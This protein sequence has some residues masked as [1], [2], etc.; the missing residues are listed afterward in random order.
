MS[1]LLPKN[2]LQR[3]HGVAQK[4]P[5]LRLAW[6]FE[7]IERHR[8][9]SNLSDKAFFE[10]PRADAEEVPQRSARVVTWERRN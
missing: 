1:V 8:P 7:L 2:N 6:G 9:R 10:P 5:Y 3:L 4:N